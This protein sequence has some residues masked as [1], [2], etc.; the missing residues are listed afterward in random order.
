MGIQDTR[1]RAARVVRFLLDFARAYRKARQ[2]HCE[3]LRS[4]IVAT[5]FALTGDSGHF[6]AH[7]GWGCSRI[8]SSRARDRWWAVMDSNH[9][10]AD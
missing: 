9:R 3:A 4:A 6:R 5:R 8:Y 1:A 2:W 7:G 10:P